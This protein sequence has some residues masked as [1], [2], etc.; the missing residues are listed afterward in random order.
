MK[1]EEMQKRSKEKVQ[2]VLDL[3]KS[4]Q[5]EVA[6]KRKITKEMFIEDVVFWIDNEKYPTLPETPSFPR[7]AMVGGPTPDSMRKLATDLME[8]S[9]EHSDNELV[10]QANQVVRNHNDMFPEE[11][12]LGE[13]GLYA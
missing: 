7:Q 11:A 6:P 12:P 13:Y 5:L 10:R 8:K 2:Q 4:L 3:M 9:K 1:P